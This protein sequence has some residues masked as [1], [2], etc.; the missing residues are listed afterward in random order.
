MRGVD[1][2]K[3][4]NI[5]RWSYFRNLLCVIFVQS[6]D[7][8]LSVCLGGDCL[9]GVSLSSCLNGGRLSVSLGVSLSSCL[10]GGRLSVSLGGDS[11]VSL[12]SCL[13]GSGFSSSGF[14]SSGSCSS[15]SISSGSRSSIGF[16]FP[17][18]LLFYQL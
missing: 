1:F 4:L 14:S 5:L 11:G 17:L 12:G 6:L 3:L 9:G 18:S 7:S 13:S 8:R 16:G 2:V 10:N 15:G